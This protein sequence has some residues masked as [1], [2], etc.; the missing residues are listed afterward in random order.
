M[1]QSHDE[2]TNASEY[3]HIRGGIEGRQ[4]GTGELAI[5]HTTINWIE[6]TIELKTVVDGTHTFG[7]ARYASV[8]D[9]THRADSVSY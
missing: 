3:T 5:A 9:T 8:E 1:A 2:T 4:N 6:E 7:H